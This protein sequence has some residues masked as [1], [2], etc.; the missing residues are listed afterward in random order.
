[1]DSTCPEFLTTF[2][3]SWSRL[4]KLSLVFSTRKSM[5]YW[6][7]Q[8]PL[9]EC[10]QL[11]VFVIGELPEAIEWCGSFT[12]CAKTK[13]SMHGSKVFASPWFAWM[14]NGWTSAFWGGKMRDFCQAKSVFC[15]VEEWLHV[16]AK[17][18]SLWPLL[19]F[20]LGTWKGYWVTS[21]RKPGTSNSDDAQPGFLR[22]LSFQATAL[23]NFL[24]DG[25]VCSKATQANFHSF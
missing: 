13:T 3:R 21:C 23:H 7:T 20:H 5:K 11:R 4:V 1:M 14:H 9:Q 24:W 12:G 2:K 6:A 25:T 18:W 16:L 15:F 8:L 19:C 17:E 10:F 22:E